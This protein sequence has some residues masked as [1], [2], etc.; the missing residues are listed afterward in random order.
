MGMC[1]LSVALADPY[2]E[3]AADFPLDDWM[4][5]GLA[6]TIGPY[7]DPYIVPYIGPYR[8]GPIGPKPTPLEF[9]QH[10]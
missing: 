9:I 3:D 10:L 2:G 4:S 6:A 7:I 8:E 1:E 5:S